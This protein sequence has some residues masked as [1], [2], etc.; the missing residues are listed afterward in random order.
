M[1]AIGPSRRFEA[2]QHFGRFQGEADINRGAI[3]GFMSLVP[4]G[5][6]H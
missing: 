6:R 4:L 2:T 1:A 3:S 5:P